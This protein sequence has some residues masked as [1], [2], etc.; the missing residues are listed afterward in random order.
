MNESAT[1]PQSNELV[2][3]ALVQCQGKVK[4]AEFDATNP[5]FK[6]RYATLGAVIEASREALFES[7]L[8]I[9]QRPTIVDNLVSVQTVIIH[10]S[11][12]TLDGGTMSLAIGENERNSDAQLAGSICTYLKR[13]A[14]ASVLGI[15]AD[16]DNDGNASPRGAA[17]RRQPESPKTAPTPLTDA[18][19]AT[20]EPVIG[21]KYRLK[22]LNRLQAAPG[23]PHR[24][25]VEGYLRSKLWISGDQTSDDFPLDKLPRDADEFVALGEAIQR[26]E[27]TMRAEVPIP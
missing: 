12:Q 3:A 25:L 24:A 1:K 27:T 17:P 26:F 13:Y 5:F 4:A 20:P 23:Q 11:G 8:A 9:L 14:W 6:S 19:K 22:I 21:P 2:S 10:K 7:G 18:A 15:Y 16:E